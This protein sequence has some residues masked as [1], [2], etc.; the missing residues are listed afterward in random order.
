MNKNDTL[1]AECN[2]KI[3]VRNEACNIFE[4]IL[5]Q[6]LHYHIFYALLNMLKKIWAISWWLPEKSKPE[7]G[8]KINAERQVTPTFFMVAVMTTELSRLLCFKLSPSALPKIWLSSKH[9]PSQEHT[10]LT[11]QQVLEQ[12]LLSIGRPPVIWRKWNKCLERS[13]FEKLVCL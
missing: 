1:K 2:V 12:A 4:N 9:I 6:S 11:G 13:L 10:G 8:Y 5:A 7:L 3:Y